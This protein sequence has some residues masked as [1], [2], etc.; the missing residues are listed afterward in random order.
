MSF[1][2]MIGVGLW[3]GFFNGSVSTTNVADATDMYLERCMRLCLQQ[4][5]VL[6]TLTCESHETPVCL[7]EWPHHAAA[8]AEPRQ[9]YRQPL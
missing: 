2:M 4:V 3:D 9:P 5:H 1:V 7:Y 6:L 8:G